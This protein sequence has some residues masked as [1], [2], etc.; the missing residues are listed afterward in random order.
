M[1]PWKNGRSKKWR[2][3]KKGRKKTNTRLTAPNCDHALFVSGQTRTMNI[4]SPH[5]HHLPFPSPSPLSPLPPT[6]THTSPPP[7]LPHRP[8]A[9]HHHQA[10]HSEV[11]LFVGDVSSESLADSH[12]AAMRRRQRRLRSWWRHE[13]LSVAAGQ[14]GGGA[15]E[16]RRPSGTEPFT[17]GDAACTSV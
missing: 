17:S 6:H 12:G 7:P 13:Q 2:K 1:K 14:R 10:F 9:Q 3:K 5:H 8:H 16:E 15:R 4:P 11:A